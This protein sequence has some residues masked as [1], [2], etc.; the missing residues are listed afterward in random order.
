MA[1]QP[2]KNSPKTEVSSD[3][4]LTAKDFCDSKADL[5]Y[6]SRVL[7]CL[8]KKFPKQVKNFSDWEAVLIKEEII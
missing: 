3:Q 7:Y 1:K 5:K 2:D 8:D 4:L 6:K